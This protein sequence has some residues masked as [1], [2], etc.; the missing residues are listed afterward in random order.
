MM[1]KMQKSKEQQRDD[2]DMNNLDDDIELMNG[3]FDPRLATT[4]KYQN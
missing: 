2:V 3:D 1:R 4:K